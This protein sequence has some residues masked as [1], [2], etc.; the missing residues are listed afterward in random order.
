MSNEPLDRY[1]DD[2]GLRLCA[3]A[4]SP[5]PPRR[6][7][8]AF[9]ATPAVAAAVLAAVLVF[10]TGGERLDVVAEA[11][12]ALSPPDAIVHMVIRSD[13]D[14]GRP[15]QKIVTQQWT[16][17]DPLRWRVVREMPDGTGLLENGSLFA[18]RVELAYADGVRRAYTSLYDRLNVTRGVSEEGLAA[19]V[20]SASALSGDAQADFRAMLASGTVR[21][22]GEHRV[23]GRPVR[24]LV[25][26]PSPKGFPPDT[27][28]VYDVDPETFAPV[29]YVIDFPEPRDLDI[30]YFVDIYERIPLTP[31]TA[32]LLQFEVPTDTEIVVG[33]AEQWSI[34]G[35]GP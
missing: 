23:D 30:E 26:E 18:G 25:G 11:R 27:R 3:A 34:P 9:L 20:P 14:V 33:D 2:F 12:A 4:A 1:L 32:Q 31:E 35:R 21:D 19:R 22:A 29:R 28:F 10:G 8:L 7:R 24:R 16:T 13:R 15:G 17:V 5:A 6:R